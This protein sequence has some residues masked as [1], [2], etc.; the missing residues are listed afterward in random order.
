MKQNQNTTP[1]DA[2]GE[3]AVTIGR[4]FGSGGRELG[5]RISER[6]GYAYY[7]KE[8]LCDAAREAG[9]ATEFF[10]RNDERAPSFFNS[11]APLSF[12]VAAHAF[13]GTSSA[14]STDSLYRAQSDFIE[15]LPQRGA[16][17]IVGR[18]AD[19][20]LRHYDRRLSVFVSAP[21]EQRVERIL[22]RQPELTADK[23]RILAEKSDKLRANFY[24][25]YTDRQ[26]GA[27]STYD[28]TIDSSRLSMDDMVDIIAMVIEKR[29]GK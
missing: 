12:G 17:V 11:L 1:A 15:S 8:L 20:I 7:D 9:I 23:A 27:A 26:W 2:R 19:Y 24:N 18:A 13:Y 5:R 29:F 16:C 28:L 4:Q 10:E 6:L 25:F 14:I 22:K 3:V 21:I